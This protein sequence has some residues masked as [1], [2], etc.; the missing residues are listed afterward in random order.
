MDSLKVSRVPSTTSR[1]QPR[2]SQDVEL[3]SLACVGTKNHDH[4]TLR[5]PL[6]LS[7]TGTASTVCSP[8]VDDAIWD[9]PLRANSQTS[10]T[11]AGLTLTPLTPPTKCLKHV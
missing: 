8:G 5:T 1:D 3:E 6:L 9:S 7:P 11:P 2:P 4:D 10:R